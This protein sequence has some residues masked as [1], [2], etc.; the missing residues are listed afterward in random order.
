MK[1]ED[2]VRNL[3]NKSKVETS[4]ETDMR[5]LGN[6][7]EHMDKL[8]QERVAGIRPNKR[9]IIM[10]SPITKLA[11]AVVIIIAI[12]IG[13]HY[14]GGSIDGASVAWAQVVEQINNYT[15][16]KCRQRIVREKGPEYPTMQVYHLNLSQRRQEVED[17]S[18]HII[19]MRG[20]DAITVE[21]YPDQMKATVTKL[22]GF[23]PR[24]DP[25]II[26]MVKR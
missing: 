25:H 10:K 4:P 1:P 5:I 20:T 16:Y 12:L 22:I 17:G 26:E 24:K 11:A 3:I 7:M 23:G 6:A 13:V 14:L 18:I 19:D 15:K 8:R 2:K 21:L 9:R